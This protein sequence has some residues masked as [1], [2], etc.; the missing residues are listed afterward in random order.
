[1]YHQKAHC[2]KVMPLPTHVSSNSNLATILLV[3]FIT[4]RYL[5]SDKESLG[6]GR[7]HLSQRSAIESPSNIVD[8]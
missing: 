2:T 1:M 7:G 4:T 3:R 6:H 8:S 5:Q